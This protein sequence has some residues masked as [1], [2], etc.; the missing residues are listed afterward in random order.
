[1]VATLARPSTTHATRMIPTPPQSDATI[2]PPLQLVLD[3]ELVAVTDPDAQG[4]VAEAL[5]LLRRVGELMLT[6]MPD[7][8]GITRNALFAPLD[9]LAALSGSRDPWDV[10][11]FEDWPTVRSA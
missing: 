9:D 5:V 4:A 2:V 1:M 11:W 10:D 3:G 7:E 6:R 8:D